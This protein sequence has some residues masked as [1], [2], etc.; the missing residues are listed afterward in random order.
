MEAGK[1]KKKEKETFTWVLSK[2]LETPE[3]WE[4]PLARPPYGEASEVPTGVGSL[5]LLRSEPAPAL[6]VD[7]DVW[8][9]SGS[10]QAI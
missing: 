7:A 8:P 3:L 5:Q 4:T 6:Q 9:L 1:K 10:V 2:A